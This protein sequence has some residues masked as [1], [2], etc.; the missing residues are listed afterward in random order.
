MNKII[1]KLPAV[2]LTLVVGV[3]ASSTAFGQA[4]IVIENVDPAGT[5][6]NDNTPATPGGG[7]S[8]TTVGQQRLNAFQHAANIWGATL[9]GGPTITVRAS[10]E[11]QPCE[12]NAGTLGSAGS[13][14][15]VRNFPNA[16]VANTW[17]GSALANTLAGV[18]LDPANPEIRARFNKKIGTAGCL[19]NS[20]WYY[21]FTSVAGAGRINLVT[22]LLHEF[23]HGLGF[24]TFTSSSDGT[25]PGGFPS[26]YDRFLFDNTAN[27]NWT[28][29]TDAERMASAINTGNLVWTGPQAHSDATLLT[30]GK[31]PQGRPRL[32]APNPVR[33]GSSVSHWDIVASPNQLMEPNISISQPHSVTTPEDLTWSLLRDIGWCGLNCPPPPPP[34]SPTPTPAPPT[35]DNFADAQVITGCWFTVYGTNNGATK[36]S[37]EPLH[38][39]GSPGSGRSVWYKFRP[40]VTANLNINTHD[41]TFD[42]ILAVYTGNTLDT[43]SLVASNDDVSASHTSSHVSFDVTAGVDYRIAVDGF[44]NFASGGDTGNISLTIGLSN[45]SV[46]GPTLLTDEGT[47][48]ALVMDSVTRVRGPFSL[49]SQHNLSPDHRTRVLVFLKT[50]YNGFPPGAFS[51]QV[52][53]ATLQTY[54]LPVED[55]QSGQWGTSLVVRLTDELPAGTLDLSVTFG[56]AP[57][58]KAKITI[59]K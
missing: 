7:N 28:G 50:H 46:T 45:C 40:T 17:F 20:Q 38:F 32:Y 29:M 55:L 37:G 25:Q 18:D 52:Q 19:E 8:G 21:G 2:L 30:Q 49:L 41:S 10:W 44:N 23:A 15:L 48:N 9:P 22:V 31:D 35:N 12:A 27:K 4:T 13:M 53:D 39:A 1:S 59:V 51:V 5:G 36:E 3:M 56:G 11:D 33:V 58:N 54:S 42:T 57:S 24:Q 34:P 6:F 16:P 26:T 43:L 47:N 14:G